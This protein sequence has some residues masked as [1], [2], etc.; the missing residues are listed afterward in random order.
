[1]AIVKLNSN[2]L[3]EIDTRRAILDKFPYSNIECLTQD[4]DASVK[5]YKIDIPGFNEDDRVDFIFER[6]LKG[7]MT[8]LTQII[9]SIEGTIRNATVTLEQVKQDLLKKYPDL[10]FQIDE[11]IMSLRYDFM[12]DTTIVSCDKFDPTTVKVK[13]IE[14]SE[15]YHR[16]EIFANLVPLPAHLKHDDVFGKVYVLRSKI[17][18]NIV[19]KTVFRGDY[20]KLINVEDLF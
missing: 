10:Y 1:M 13:T 20:Y 4:P 12:D 6:Q 17:S 19:K 15:Y 3:H 11:F 16:F 9:P 18:D 7:N 14:L 8:S 5:E 2:M